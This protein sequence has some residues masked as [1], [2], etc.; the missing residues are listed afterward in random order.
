MNLH[1][2]VSEASKRIEGKLNVTPLGYSHWLKCYLK[3][4]SEQVTGSFKARGAMNKVLSLN[5]DEIQRGIIT[6]STGNHA[7]AVTNAIKVYKLENPEATINSSIYLPENG[8][9]AKIEALQRV[10][11]NLKLFGTDSIQTEVEALRVAT[12]TNAVYIS[13]YNDIMV[14]AGQGTIA[15]EM[16]NQINGKLDAVFVAVGGGGLISGIAAYLK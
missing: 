12:E 8:S 3:L 6:A 4:E 1:Q 10:G 16:L 7:M 13:P 14:A 9:T 5:S 15:V 2:Q 11:A